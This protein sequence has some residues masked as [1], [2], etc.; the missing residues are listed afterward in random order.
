MTTYRWVL[1]IVLQLQLLGKATKTWWNEFWICVQSMIEMHMSTCQ[2]FLNTHIDNNYNEFLKSKWWLITDTSKEFFSS[3]V[4]ESFLLSFSDIKSILVVR[5]FG[6]T[7]DLR[8]FLLFAFVI[9]LRA[10]VIGFNGWCCQTSNQ[11]NNIWR[12]ALGNIAIT[13]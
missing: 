3:D 4:C 11:C 6:S 10:F 1:H 9:P 5:D 8:R 2:Y 12:W 7:S 13:Q